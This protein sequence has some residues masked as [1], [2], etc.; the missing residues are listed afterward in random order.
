MNQLAISDDDKI[1]LDSI[2]KIG[3]YDYIIVPYL[4]EF[5][6]QDIANYVYNVHGNL[7][8]EIA[9]LV[10]IDD[11]YYTISRNTDTTN[12]GNSTSNIDESIEDN[13]NTT[14]NTDA[15]NT[16]TNSLSGFQNTTYKDS[17]KTNTVVDET[18]ISNSG[19]T[20]KNE[21][22]NIGNYSNN[23]NVKMREN[24]SPIESLKEYQYL[25]AITLNSFV[26]DVIHLI[27]YYIN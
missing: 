14:R 26:L 12:N 16:L 21:S 1:R 2:L 4:E 23:T 18:I 9:N 6:N 3:Y 10:S 20:R 7:W 8:N 25:N 17:D 15:T 19:S 27:T 24:L 11:P 22:T 13:S 5:S